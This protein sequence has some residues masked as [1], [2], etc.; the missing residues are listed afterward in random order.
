MD[1]STILSQVDPCTMPGQQCSRATAELSYDI[2]GKYYDQD[3][4][5]SNSD[6]KKRKIKSHSGGKILQ[7][8][9][10]QVTVGS[11]W[12]LCS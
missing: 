9:A 12:D 5:D 2:S 3:A 1:M 4:N 10:V 8:L 11:T 6:K 7:Q